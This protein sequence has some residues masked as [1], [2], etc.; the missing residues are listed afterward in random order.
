MILTQKRGAGYWLWKPYIILK[1]LQSM[2]DG[3]FLMYADAG[4]EYIADVSPLFDVLEADK[5]D[6][7]FFRL[8]YKQSAWTKRD[9][10]VLTGDTLCEINLTSGCDNS[11]CQSQLQLNA[12]FHLWRKSADSI[13]FVE[14]WLE[15]CKDPRILTDIPNEMVNLL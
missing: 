12:A 6:Y 9:A 11:L 10:F 7:V 13:R 1:T 2:T 8:P 14:Q 3:D 15:F 4:S 5:R